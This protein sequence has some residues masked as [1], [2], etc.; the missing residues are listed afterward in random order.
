MQMIDGMGGMVFDRPE[1]WCKN[2]NKQ[3]KGSLKLTFIVAGERH[4]TRFF[5]K[6]SEDTHR[7]MKQGERN[8]NVKPGLFIDQVITTPVSFNFYLQFHAAIKGTPRSAHYHV[9]E[10]DVG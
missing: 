3:V 5:S 9:L 2:P 7:A 10:D 8:G 4:H 6:K 1:A